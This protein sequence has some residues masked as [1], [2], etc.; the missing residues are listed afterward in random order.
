MVNS[1][2]EYF[3]T[4]IR[5][6]GFMKKIREYRPTNDKDQR[7]KIPD[8][9]IIDLDTDD[10]FEETEDFPDTADNP[11]DPSDPTPDRHVFSFS[12]H[13]AVHAVFISI[14]VIA[15][16]L[17]VYRI[18]TYGNFI[19]Q[20]DIFKDGE[21][22]YG[23]DS[24][25]DTIFPL[26]DE[27]GQI[28]PADRDGKVNVLLLGNSPFSDDRDS[29]DG[30]ANMIAE[31]TGAN[32][33]NCSVSGSYMAAQQAA[34]NAELSPM[35]AYTPYWL[36]TLTYT[37]VIDFYYED[38]ARSLGDAIPPEA[39]EVFETLSTLDMNTID[40]VAFMYDGT[41]YLMGHEMYNDT[42][43]TDIT[44][45]TGNL[46]ASIELL[47]ENFPHIRIIVMSP[48]YAFGIDENGEYISSD[49][50]TYGQHYLSTYFNKE[51]ATCYDLGVSFV[52]NLYITVTEDNARQ[53][54]TDNIHLN[55]EGRKRVADRFIYALNYYN[56]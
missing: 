16:S 46:Q 31:R 33:I 27:N 49:I 10:E 6:R 19:S 15:V 26:L 32:V 11:A 25:F 44:Q 34:F 50:Q 21:G 12:P 42:N 23:Y 40:V 43:A 3:P 35:D 48:T 47:Q 29:S 54:L 17:I 37:D 9:R 13:S 36:C 8:I 5:M 24:E 41:D 4:R 20:E 51:F 55:L 38:A 53:Y 18:F 45:F 56:G 2:P 39:R 30:L 22:S 14:A 7:N 1:V 52:D 28:I